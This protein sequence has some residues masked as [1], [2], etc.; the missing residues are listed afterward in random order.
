MPNSGAL[1]QSQVLLVDA[2]TICI[3]RSLEAYF[4]LDAAAVDGFAAM[5]AP[6]PWRA[7]AALTC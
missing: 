5:V 4:A 6:E 7:N 2:S 3:G 1:Q